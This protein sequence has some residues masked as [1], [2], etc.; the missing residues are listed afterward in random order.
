MYVFALTALLIRVLS[1]G[2]DRARFRVA[3]EGEEER[4][5]EIEEYWSGR[6]LSAGEAVW[7][8]L[9]FHITRKRPAMTMLPM[10]IPDSNH[11]HQYHR[12]NGQHSMLSCLDRYFHRPL[13]MFFRGSV[14]VPFNTLTY[15]KY[16]RLFRLTKF[17][18]N[19][20]HRPGHYAE[21]DIPE[22]QAL[23]LVIQRQDIYSH[24]TR[25]QPATPSQGERFYLR[26]IL[27]TRPAASFEDA[28]TVV[29]V[30]YRTFQAAAIAMGVF[31]NKQ[32]AEYAMAEAVATLRTPRQLRFLFIHLLVNE[33]CPTP[34]SIWERFCQDL[35]RDYYLQ[36][37]LSWE[38]GEDLALQDLSRYLE[39]HGK[40]LRQYGLPQPVQHASEVAHEI[41]RWA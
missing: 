38:L 22:G 33:C 39:E 21:R 6:Y 40:T 19:L 10:H 23:M 15:T 5:D 25:L 4:I 31:A 18:A 7:R 13:G 3:A 29:G 2:P 12:R 11:C 26:A 17:D 8:I 32:E 14:D 37:E 30:I 27:A 20:L 24:V 36:N 16:Y 35:S 34:L 41:R 9:G 1:T 28:Q